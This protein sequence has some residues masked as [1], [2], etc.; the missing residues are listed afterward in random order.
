MTS[1]NDIGGGGGG[2]GGGRSGHHHHH[3]HRRNSSSNG[4]SNNI[5]GRRISNVSV[6]N[7]NSVNNL[8]SYSNNNNNSHHN[9]SP[10]M[11][12]DKEW[13]FKKNTKYPES[14]DCDS[15]PPPPPPEDEPPYFDELPPPL[16]HHHNHLSH[17]NQLDLVGSSPTDKLSRKHRSN[18]DSSQSKQQQLRANGLQQHKA[19]HHHHHHHH[20]RNSKSSRADSVLSSDSDIRFTRRKLGD[21]QK[22]GCA[23]IAGFLLILLFAG[24]VVYVGYTYLRP[25]PLPDRIFRGRLRVVE[26]DHWTPELADQNSS[27]FQQR[28]RDYRERIN[29]IMR[30][31]DLREPYE[32]SEILALDG[33]EGEDVTLHFAMYFDPYADLVSTADL[34]S[35]LMEEIT[36]DHPRYLRNLTIDPSSL[37]I[38]E[39]LGQFDDIPGTSSSPLGGKD[40]VI[41]EIITTM[42][43]PRKCEPLRLSYC[44]SV[45]YNFTTYPNIFGHGSV[46]EVEADLISF[47]ELVDAECFRQAF[48]FICRLLQPPCEYRRI[49]EPTPGKIC[50]QYCQAFW[51]GCGDRLP[52]RF[53]KY[54][55]CERFP[56]STAIQSCHSRPGCATE[57]QSN[58]LS[59]R[60]CDGVADCPDLSDE[61]TCTFC[62]YGAIY[63]GRGRVCYARNARCDGKMDCPDGSDEKDCLSI[64][65]QVTY[66]TFPAPIVPYRPRFY[67]EGYAVFSEKGITGK[68]C[69]V[70]METNEYVRNTVAES[71]CKALGYER[72][73]YS[74]VRNDT[75]PNTSYVRVLDP[76]ASE[77]SFVRTTCQS[78]QSLYVGCGQLECGVQSALPSNPNVGLSKMAAP[79]DWPWL[80]ALF[81]A[82][83]HVCDG[84]LVSSD[85]VL[86]TESCFQGQP[87]ATWI[88]M[89]GAVRLSSNA[90]W[91][92]RR[93]IIGMVKSPVEGSTAAL[94]RLENPVVY[95]DFVRP[96][97]LPDIPLKETIDRSDLVTPTPHAARFSKAR[98]RKRI[99]E[100]RQYF[101]T[102]GEEDPSEDY[103]EATEA[104]R[105]SINEFAAEF[106]DEGDQIPK[107]EA[108][109]A[110]SGARNA[111]PLPENSP[112]TN[113]Y[114]SPL[115]HIGSSFQPPKPKQSV[116]TNCNTLGWSRQRDHLQRVQ[117]KISDMKPCENVSIATVNSMCTEAAYHKQD[118]SEEE[119]AGSP[120]V[121]LLSTERKW[122]LVGV[123]SWRI[124]CAPNGV[125]RPRMYDKI[126]S[127]SQWIREIIAAS[128]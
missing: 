61:N 105:Y 109:G 65:P 43:P 125:A 115:N 23:L 67:S 36:S 21:N 47:R 59:S 106:A 123:A 72:V 5:V 95:S 35:I 28:A 81:R 104:T 83:T 56:E 97:C 58:A 101:E 50:R 94:V 85:W 52:E 14:D 86:T 71:L 12:L 108:V 100:Y 18:S 124:A 66:L 32:G 121:C 62:P 107:A 25:E 60:L 73:E 44:R 116:W 79:G 3:H 30:R 87:K 6:N 74:E 17:L 27:R 90:P 93:R 119:F 80:A 16:H 99:K 24:V 10:R 26:G 15:L 48:D 4:G 78:K 49:E 51:N 38:K 53:K 57:L 113:N 64:S 75:E 126:T 33:N 13:D 45:G 40:D 8:N 112:Q 11:D 117:L 77:I 37:I 7:N 82:D 98:Q 103:G 34:H 22:C 96:I 54:M 127:N 118:C 31:S 9:N 110:V 89:F 63:C 69:S 19:H 29:L 102:P 122:A 55:D 70:G 111:Y 2:A 39:V 114:I 46:E 128:V 68:L 120:V 1:S 42:R 88:A 76:R 41:N 91:T 20:H 84:T 92:Q